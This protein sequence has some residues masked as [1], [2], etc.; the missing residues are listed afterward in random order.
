MLREFRPRSTVAKIPAAFLEG[1][2]EGEERFRV[3]FPLLLPALSSVEGL[4]V[5]LQKTVAFI[6]ATVFPWAE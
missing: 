3:L 5:F 1:R 4:H 2:T 6:M